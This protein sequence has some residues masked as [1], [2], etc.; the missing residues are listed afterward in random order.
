[1]SLR[2]A[3]ISAVLLLAACANVTQPPVPA[4]P[5]ATVPGAA[6][7]DSGADTGAAHEGDGKLYHLVAAE[8]QLRIVARRGGPLAS[9][10]HNHVIASRNLIGEFTV[11]EPLERSSFSLRVP[12][13]LLTID[14]PGLRAGRG[15]EFPPDVPMSAREGTRDN[16]L[17]EALL[18]AE[19]YP[20]I[21]LE[22]RRIRRGSGS[23]FVAA[24][25]VDLKGVITEIDMPADLEL[26]ARRLRATGR[27]TVAQSRLG[28]EPFSV[29][30]GALKVQ[31]TLEIEYELV[32][33]SR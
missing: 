24:V 18:D 28:L 1:M 6:R 13:A 32:A 19:R 14:E 3:C 31:D 4:S 17:G 22:S 16:L 21:A 26:D 23:V 25:A 10:G 9:A 2:S 30:M 8:S 7:S 33:R 20:G 27:T 29:M 11:R 12:V 15:E 5:G